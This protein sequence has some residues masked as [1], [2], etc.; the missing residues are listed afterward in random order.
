MI[1]RDKLSLLILL[2]LLKSVILSSDLEQ[3]ILNSV[4]PVWM[5]ENG[6]LGEDALPIVGMFLT[7]KNSKETMKSFGIETRKDLRKFMM[8]ITIS[9]QVTTT[10][11]DY[12]QSSINHQAESC[13]LNTNRMTNPFES[14]LS[15]LACVFTSRT[16]EFECKACICEVI[17]PRYPDACSLCEAAPAIS[18]LTAANILTASE[19]PQGKVE[20]EQ[21]AGKGII[22]TG[23]GTSVVEIVKADGTIFSMDHCDSTKTSKLSL[24][25]SRSS[26]S[27]NGLVAC[28]G[29]DGF[30]TTHSNCLKLNEDGGGWEEYKTLSREF[31]SHTSWQSSDLGLVLLGGFKTKQKTESV[32]TQTQP[33][34]LM[35]TSL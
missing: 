13:S 35:K 2:Q 10:P 15:F 5:M 25:S 8:T 19:E 6:I 11:C 12:C 20:S 26:H 18:Y 32:E 1:L 16:V 33:F 14:P 29:E 34:L 21:F 27:Q 28:G 9:M 7:G 3:T 31:S 23:G 17:C 24:T 22:V 30:M 4:M